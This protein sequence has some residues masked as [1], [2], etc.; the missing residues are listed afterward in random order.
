MKNWLFVAWSLATGGAFICLPYVW[1][2]Q[3][4]DMRAAIHLT[5]F[6]ALL[7]IIIR[8]KKRG[9]LLD[10]KR[11]TWRGYVG[12][13]V[14]CIPIF[15]ST[16]AYR[17]FV[18]NKENEPNKALEG[19]RLLVTPAAYAAVAPSNRLPQLGR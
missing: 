5:V 14:F 13:I 17:A 19:R 10:E 18:M 11:N 4:F 9:G 15:G 7:G 16:F 2:P 8:E 6:F 3:P 1:W 12:A